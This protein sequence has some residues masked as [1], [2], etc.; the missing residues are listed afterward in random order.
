[1][2]QDTMATTVL[3]MRSMVKAE[4]GDA[5][6]DDDAHNDADETNDDDDNYGA[7]GYGIYPDDDQWP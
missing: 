5:D 2:V 7:D 4:C 1:M 6:G 3:W